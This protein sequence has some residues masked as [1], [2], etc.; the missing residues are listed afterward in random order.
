MSEWREI[1]QFN[2]AE[3]FA[4]AILLL[5]VLIGGGILIYQNSTESLPPELF[6]QSAG[7]AT[8]HQ[9]ARLSG[10]DTI[11][12]SPSKPET[13]STRTVTNRQLIPA[14]LMVNV[15]TAPA[16]SLM[17][18]PRVGPAL[19]QRILA[20]RQDLGRFDS[21]E[22]LVRVRGIGRK[23]LESIRPYC[24]VGDAHEDTTSHPNTNSLRK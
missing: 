16:E 10:T 4:L 18:L 13:A 19:C 2:R 24:T 14:P 6:F 11:S 20:L 22:Q 21:L 3:T 12:P 1:F 15:N 7:A 23:T 17:M 8:T 9:D 5:L